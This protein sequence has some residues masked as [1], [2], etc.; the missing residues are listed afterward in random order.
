ML[1]TVLVP[2]FNY[3]KYLP[4]ALASVFSQT[5][6]PIQLIVV[7]DGSSDDSRQI[8]TQSAALAREAEIE[9]EW[10]FLGKNEGKLAALNSVIS[11]IR[12]GV[13]CILDSDD[14]LRSS[15]ITRT[16][17]E[18]FR[19]RATDPSVAFVY[20]D[21]RLVN[22]EGTT[23]GRGK[24]TAFSPMLLERASFIPDCGLTITGSLVQAAPYDESVRVGTKHHKWSK[25]VRNGA[26]G[27]YVPM[28]GFS[29][30]IHA[31]NMSGINRRLFERGSLKLEDRL[32]SGLWPTA[33]DVLAASGPK[34]LIV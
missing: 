17:T 32:L 19:S 27:V 7:D 10:H 30:R 8:I 28:I 14:Y 2:N 29:Y 33:G 16:S 20:T 22:S 1:A 3:G 18:L 11:R 25:I 9:Y 5:H 23:L 24:S 31:T 34:K 13:T 15:F 12:G 6:R 21:C 26:K 4:D